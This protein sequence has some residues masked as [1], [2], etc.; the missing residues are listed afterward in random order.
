MIVE[1]QELRLFPELLH[2]EEPHL[3]VLD[4]QELIDHMPPEKWEIPQDPYTF[5]ERI[6]ENDLDFMKA[7]KI[8]S[9]Q[10]DCRGLIVEWIPFL[11]SVERGNRIN[12]RFIREGILTTDL[13]S[14]ENCNLFYEVFA[15]KLAEDKELNFEDV[16]ASVRNAFLYLLTE[17]EAKNLGHEKPAEVIQE[18]IGNATFLVNRLAGRQTHVFPP[19]DEEEIL[20]P[21]THSG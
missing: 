6:S 9:F 2:R 14:I 1:Q 16:V 17:E 18:D 7:H 13:N 3:P 5:W 21:K 11:D 10:R 19:Q 4:T 8:E 12:I 15:P 20:P